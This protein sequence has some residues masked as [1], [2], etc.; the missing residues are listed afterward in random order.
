MK[1]IIR[2][3]TNYYFKVLKINILGGGSCRPS[4]GVSLAPIV[5]LLGALACILIF[6]G[7]D[8]ISTYGPWSLLGCSV[9]AIVL[10]A[11][12]GSLNKRGLRVGFCRGARQVAPTI[13]MLM[14]IATVS[15]TWML[16]GVVPT[17]IDYGLS[18]LNPSLFLATTCAV[19]AVISVLTGSS[20]STIATIGVAFMGIGSVLGYGVGWVAGAVISGAYFG[21][22]VSPLSDT[23]VLASSSCGVDLFDHIRY[24]MLTSLPA[25]A[26]TLVV[27]TVAGFATDTASHADSEAMIGYLQETFNITPWVLVI[28]ALTVIMIAMRI[29]TILILAVSSLLG[30]IGMY[31]F[32]PQIIDALV[33]VDAS[34]WTHITTIASSL[35]DETALATGHET[36]DSLVATSGVTGMLPTIFL[37]VC[38]MAFGAAMIGTGMLDSI[39]RASTRH[40]RNRKA[41]VTTTVASGLFL[42]SATADQYLSIIIGG[43]MYRNLY[44]RLGLESRLLSRS[45][46]DS[47]SVT[48]VLIPWNSCGLTQSAV[49]GVATVAYLPFCVFN[50]LSPLMTLLLGVTGFKVPTAERLRMVTSEDLA[51]NG[52]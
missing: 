52:E 4:L 5:C 17:L 28:P 51:V 9:L 43:N 45:L 26:V 18:R 30:V 6:A 41:A 40:I 10:A 16:S 44:R 13:P 37:I 3:S 2:L 11:L 12:S 39:T 14:F 8:A 31:V 48:S 34:L 49:L 21:D 35:W 33:G 19:C 47:I 25:M 32:Q 15:A 46:E 42:N 1:S 22:K 50:Y 36:L 23:T 24:L 7:A 29:N 38:A 27:F 20:W